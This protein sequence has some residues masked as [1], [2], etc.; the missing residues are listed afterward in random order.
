MNAFKRLIV[1]IGHDP[2]AVALARA[3]L[4]YLVPLLAGF[5][6]TQVEGVT[7]PTWAGLALAA[8]GL[9]RVLEGVFIDAL[10]KPT[11]NETYP[12]PPAGSGPG[13]N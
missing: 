8:A 1:G 5:A 13:H 11:Q 9:I 2:K 3:V 6:V 7:N 10:K 12:T 4:L